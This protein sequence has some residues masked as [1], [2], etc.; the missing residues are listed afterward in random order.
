MSHPSRLP[1]VLLPVLI[2][3]LLLGAC[4]SMGVPT[5]P[6]SVRLIGLQPGGGGLFEQALL[7]DLR[8]TNPNRQEIRFDGMT[9]NLT[10]N[11]KHLADGVSNK[12]VTVPA[13]GEA[14]LQVKA[15]ASTLSL[16]RQMFALADQDTLS[17]AIAGQ[18]FVA[19]PTLDH[20][21]PYETSGEV[22]LMGAFRP[23]HGGTAR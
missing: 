2:L 23:R 22:D 12:A 5:T 14:V 8:V 13:L 20:T 3:G 18:V 11:G 9:F 4:A 6:P 1:L 19:G 16:A 17:Y 15:S 7:L 10:V 21:V